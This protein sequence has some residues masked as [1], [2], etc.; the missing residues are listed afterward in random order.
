[1]LLVFIYKQGFLGRF[2]DPIRV[3]RIRENYHWVPKTRENWVPR[4]REIG[5]PCRYLTFSLKKTVYKLKQ[6]VRMYIFHNVLYVLSR[7]GL[8]GKGA[9]GQFL[10]ED[11][12]DVIHDVIV[13]KSCVFA[14]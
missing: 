9:P 1:M 10:L 7:A 5:S 14:D 13:C 4:I 3:P 6:K 11:P 2:K 12:Y 8:K